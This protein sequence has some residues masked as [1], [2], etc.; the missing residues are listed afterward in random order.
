MDYPLPVWFHISSQAAELTREQKPA[1]EI[2]MTDLV[3]TFLV[4]RYPGQ[5]MSHLA[6][7]FLDRFSRVALKLQTQVHELNH[8]LGPSDLY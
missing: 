3:K 1:W 2:W 8:N 7:G 4:R 5:N 6:D